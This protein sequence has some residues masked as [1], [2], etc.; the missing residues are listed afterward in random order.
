[1]KVYIS[2]DIEGVAGITHWDEADKTHR[3]Y[4]EFRQQ[5]TRETIA[6]IEGA[7]AGGATEILIKDAHDSGRNLILDMLP[8]DVRII[9]SWAGHPL[10]MIQEIDSSFDAIFMIGYHAAAG[11]EGN[12][13]AHTLTLRAQ[14]ILINEQPASEFLVHGLAASALGVPVALVTGDEALMAEVAEVNPSITRCAVKRGVGQSTI[15]MTP[16]AAVKAIR[17]AAK[18][19]LE[20]KLATKRLPL[21]KAFSVAIVYS[22]PVTAYRMSHYP[23]A[24]H[25]GDRTVRYETKDITDVLKLLSFIA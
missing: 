1:M 9:R 18:T 20:G 19:A 16:V 17:E 7:K 21:P 12:A 14:R 22:D 23:G 8:E 3:D 13:L 24:E 10:S 5:M 15:S 25:A 6:A 2:V 11:S 4:P